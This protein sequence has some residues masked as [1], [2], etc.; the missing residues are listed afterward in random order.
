ME[1]HKILKLII[2]KIG[3]QESKIVAMSRAITIIMSHPGDRESL[4]GGCLYLD[5]AKLLPLIEH[6]IH[7]A[8]I[9]LNSLKME[10]DQVSTRNEPNAKKALE[11][12][13]TRGMRGLSDSWDDL[14]LHD[15]AAYPFGDSFDGIRIDVENFRETEHWLVNAE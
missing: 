1:K 15:L 11:I 3:A 8:E 6:E 13:Y 5:K 10:L 4:I 2:A 12:L 7:E 14:N 9:E